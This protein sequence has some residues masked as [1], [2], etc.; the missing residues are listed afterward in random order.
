MRAAEVAAQDVAQE[1]RVLHG[2]R[3]VEAE[4]LGDPL[5]LA[6]RGIGR[7]QQRHRIAGQTHD[8]EDH[9]GDQPERD[10][11]PEQPRAEE[12]DERAHDGGRGRGAPA[13][14]LSHARFSLKLKRRSS[15][16]WLGFGVNSTYFCSP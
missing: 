4:I 14:S 9:G 6:A 16:C 8:H 1:H 3:A 12:P 5:V 7:D 2:Q 11:R 13:A 10:E 15:I